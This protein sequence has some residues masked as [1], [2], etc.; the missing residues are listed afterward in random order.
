MIID[1]LYS[2]CRW[3]FATS[4][5]ELSPITRTN[6]CLTVCFLDFQVDVISATVYIQCLVLMVKSCRYL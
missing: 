2:S 4:Y 5:L 1:A 3:N 6:Q